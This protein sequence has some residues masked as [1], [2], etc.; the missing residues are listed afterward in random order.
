LAREILIAKD[1][2]H[3]LAGELVGDAASFAASGEL[4]LISPKS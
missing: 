1:Q 3:K 4:P 2:I